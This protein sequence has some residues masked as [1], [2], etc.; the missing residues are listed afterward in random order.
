M[1]ISSKLR[2]LNVAG[3]EGVANKEFLAILLED[4][5]PGLI[6]EGC[7]HL[8]DEALERTRKRLLPTNETDKEQKY[9]PQVR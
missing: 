8:T 3:L 2:S 5:I 1:F 4:H 7:D 6:V 9:V